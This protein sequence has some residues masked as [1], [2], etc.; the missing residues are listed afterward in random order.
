MIYQ[1]G[2]LVLNVHDYPYPGGDPS[3]YPPAGRSAGSSGMGMGGMG[4]GGMGSGGTGGSTEQSP[5]GVPYRITMNDLMMTVTSM[6]EPSSWDQQGGPGSIGQLGTAMLVSQTA[7][8]HRQIQDL[9][10][11][12]RKGTAGECQTVEID[13]A[14]C[15]STRTSWISSFLPAEEG[16]QEVDRKV[17]GVHS[18]AHQFPRTERSASAANWVRSWRAARVETSS[19]ATFRWSDALETPQRPDEQYVFEGRLRARTFTQLRG[20]GDTQSGVVGDS[21]AVSAINR[22]SI[23]QTSAYCLR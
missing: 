8:V 11:E 9:L 22:L 14:G 1:V 18:P 3:M 17:L 2:D 4:G 21:G 10:E 19:K 5:G 15:C 6:V 20:Q 13:C 16:R 12:L 7:D 23:G